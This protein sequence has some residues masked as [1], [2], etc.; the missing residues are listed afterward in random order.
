MFFIDF[1]ISYLLT[2][3]PVLS[4]KLVISQPFPVSEEKSI[5]YFVLLWYLKI[6]P[7]LAIFFYSWWWRKK[8]MIKETKMIWLVDLCTSR[9]ANMWLRNSAQLVRKKTQF[10]FRPKLRLSQCL[11]CSSLTGTISLVIYHLQI[12]VKFIW[13]NCDKIPLRKRIIL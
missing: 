4:G 6:N 2:V 8:L 13:F 12:K 1:L 9:A 10:R 11:H 5:E 7:F 3:D